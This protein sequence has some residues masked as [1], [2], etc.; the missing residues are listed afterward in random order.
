MVREA[1]VMPF[2]RIL[3]SI[4]SFARNRLF[5]VISKL[6]RWDNSAASEASMIRQGTD[7]NCCIYSASSLK[8]FTQAGFESP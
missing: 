4:P 3:A 8:Q 7:R 6:K 1:E 5:N 2:Q